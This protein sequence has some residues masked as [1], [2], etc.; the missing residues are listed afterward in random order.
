V[1]RL[2]DSSLAARRLGQLDY[3]LYASPSY[4]QRYGSP[5]TAQ[6][7]SLHSL[8]MFSATSQHQGWSM[9]LGEE[10]V[11]IDKNARVFVNS[12]FAARDACASGLGIAKLP[13]LVGDDMLK[14]KR[15]QRVL[16]KWAHPSVPVHALF[17]STRYLTPK[18]RSF[19]DHA[20][21]KFGI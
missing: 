9:V 2:A 16:P 3:G 5:K 8:V 19:I 11:L 17:P 15:L 20:V 7:L 10:K 13:I 1:G 14:D 12:T 4:L 18:V 6:A 21:A